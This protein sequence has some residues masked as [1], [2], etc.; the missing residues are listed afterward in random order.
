MEM[1]RGTVEEADIRNRRKQREIQLVRLEEIQ[2]VNLISQKN[3]ED[4]QKKKMENRRELIATKSK[5][6]KDIQDKNKGM[7]GKQME[8]NRKQ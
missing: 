4:I 7:E 6:K 1:I 3:T 5:L 8:E 2:L